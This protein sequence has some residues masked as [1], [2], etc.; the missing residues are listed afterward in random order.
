MTP[1]PRLQPGTIIHF[2]S[3]AIDVEYFFKK[4]RP[5][6]TIPYSIITSESDADSPERKPEKLVTDDLPISWYATNPPLQRSKMRAARSS[7]HLPRS[8]QISSPD[9]LSRPLPRDAKLYKSV[10]G[11]RTETAMARLGVVRGKRHMHWQQSNFCQ[12]WHHTHEDVPTGN[13]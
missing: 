11:Q 1:P 8:E 5:N 9:S 10:S 3:H 2:D 7:N 4:F 13:L 6:T 12:L